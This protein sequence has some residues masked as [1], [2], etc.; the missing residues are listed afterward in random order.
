M[1]KV[2]EREFYRERA[3]ANWLHWRLV[4]PYGIKYGDM[5]NM[6]YD[7]LMEAN[8]ALD[9]YIEKEEERMNEASKRGRYS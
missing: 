6:D 4:L 5:R 2:D 3:R 7:E 1:G 9:I 8:A